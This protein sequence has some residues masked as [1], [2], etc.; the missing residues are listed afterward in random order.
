MTFPVLVWLI[1]GSAGGRF[2][3]VLAAAAAGWWFGF[4]YFLAGLY[5]IGIA[6]LVDA[7]TFGWLMPFAVA[8]LPAGLALFTAAGAGLARFLWTRGATRV[9]A[10]AVALTIAEW[11]RGHVLSGFPWNAFGYGLT[12]PLML[13]QGAALIG[14]W[15]LTFVA[16]AVFATPA[17]LADEAADTP[18]PWLPLMC[19]VAVL[20][21]LAGYG[22]LRL[23]Q[24]PTALVD[25]VRL[26]IM[27][28]NLPQDEKFSY[29]ARQQV[30]RRYVTLSDR[31][32]G[33]DRT[34]VKD[35]THLIWPESAFP[36]FL[37]ARARGAGAD[38][39]AAAARHRADHRRGAAG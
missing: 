32:T 22:A 30:M 23:W 6:F 5:W 25:G 27:Q 7:Q 35:V 14:L 13:A 21:A 4:G 34:G 29:A 16:V 11:L 18:R 28:P 20:A 38:Q 26:R 33:P 15:G 2:G 9:L 31:A 1:D 39:G 36:F 12:Q 8:G 37:L 24:T 10:L 3:G 17:V 19:G